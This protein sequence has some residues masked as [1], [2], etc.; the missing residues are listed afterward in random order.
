[1]VV[2]HCNTLDT[3]FLFHFCLLF[4]SLFTLSIFYV[5]AD[6]EGCICCSCWTITSAAAPR[7]S[8]SPS[9][10]PSASAGCTVRDEPTQLTDLWLATV[11][12][13]GTCAHRKWMCV[14]CADTTPVLRLKVPTASTTTSQTWLVIDHTRWWSTVGLTS[15]PSSA[16]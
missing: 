3:E 5:L 7:C 15:P 12:A 4:L 10:S 8:S 11:Q 2:R 6:R 9:A 14:R 1:M 16:L 13:K